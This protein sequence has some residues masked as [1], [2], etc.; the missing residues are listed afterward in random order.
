MTDRNAE[1]PPIGSLVEIVPGKRWSKYEHETYVGKGTVEHLSG[2]HAGPWV[3][4]KV[5][6]LGRSVWLWPNEM[7]VVEEV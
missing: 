5:H 4:V 3:S 2:G 7:R 6:D 1:A